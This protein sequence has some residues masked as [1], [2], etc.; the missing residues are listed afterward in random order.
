MNGK[1]PQL[2]SAWRKG[3]ACALDGGSRSECPYEDRRNDLGHVTFSRAYIHAWNEGF[4]DGR[5]QALQETK[6]VEKT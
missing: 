2:R 3:F 5:K 4:D 6:H 1:H